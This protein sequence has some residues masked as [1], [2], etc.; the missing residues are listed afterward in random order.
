MIYTTRWDTTGVRVFLS[1]SYVVEIAV[2]LV[3]VIEF[4][5][6]LAVFWYVRVYIQGKK[7]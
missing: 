5:I 6:F 2:L 4:F 3:G 7:K 1:D